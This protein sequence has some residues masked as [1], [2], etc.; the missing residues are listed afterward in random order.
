MID[1]L[2]TNEILEYEMMQEQSQMTLHE[3]QFLENDDEDDSLY[4]L[5]QEANPLNV[6]P[7]PLIKH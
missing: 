5:D 2:Q 6:Q 4:I 1:Y 7:Q 3:R